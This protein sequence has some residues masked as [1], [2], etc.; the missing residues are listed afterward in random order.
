MLGVERTELLLIDVMVREREASSR[1]PIA[2]AIRAA[3]SCD[4][5]RPAPLVE[6]AV[7]GVAKAC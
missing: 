6:V 1:G 7:D 3:G 5:R 4:E 2:V